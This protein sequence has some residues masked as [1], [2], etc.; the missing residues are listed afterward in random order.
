MWQVSRLAPKDKQAYTI[1]V[2]RRRHPERIVIWAKP[3]P[4]IGGPDVVAVAVPPPPGQTRSDPPRLLTRVA[5]R[6]SE[7]HQGGGMV[8]PFSHSVTS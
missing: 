7:A 1:T 5:I 8:P 4:G 3:T 2:S 6:P